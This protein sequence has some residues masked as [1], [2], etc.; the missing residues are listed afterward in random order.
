MVIWSTQSLELKEFHRDIPRYAMLSHVWGVEGEEVSFR[1]FVSL[2]TPTKSKSGFHKIQGACDVAQKDGVDWIWIDTNCI[3]KSSSAELTE[4]INS[5]YNWYKN[6]DVCYAYLDDVPWFD[7]AATGPG[8]GR[9]C[10]RES[11]WLLRGWTLQ[12]LIAPPRLEFFSNEWRKIGDRKDLAADISAATGIDEWLLYGGAAEGL[13]QVSTAKKMSWAAR[14]V[15]TRIEDVAYCLLGIFDVNMPLLYGE[16]PKA[17]MRLQEEIIKTTNDHTIFCWSRNESVPLKWTSMLAP[18]PAAFL[19]AGHYVP[20]DAWDIPMPC[21]MTNLGLSI[22]LPVIYTLTQLFVVLDAVDGTLDEN[23]MRACIAVQRTNPRRSGSNILDRN[24]FINHPVI[25]SK[26]A[27]DTRE[28]YHLYIWSRHVRRPGTLHLHGRYK[29]LGFK[30]GVLLFVDPTATR[31]LSPGR[32]DAPLGSMGY[33]II[34][35]PPGSFDEDTALFR[36][37]KGTEIMSSALMRIRFK[38]PQEPDIYLFFAVMTTL[39]GKEVWYCSVHLAEEVSYIKLALRETIAEG[40]LDTEEGE[41]LTEEALIYMSIQSDAWKKNR[42]QLTARTADESL[43]VSV[44]GSM[45]LQPKANVRAAMLSGKCESQYS[46]PVSATD[47]SPVIYGEDEEEDYDDGNDDDDE[48]MDDSE[49]AEDW[50][51]S[52]EGK[53]KQDEDRKSEEGFPRWDANSRQSSQIFSSQTLS[54]AS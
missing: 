16:G 6:A 5:M 31:L 17:F 12:E 27:T 36:L 7:L 50:S 8:E 15:T 14:R 9:H 45:T 25:L 39:T 41:V 54:S 53:E 42:R 48:Y 52:N 18:S 28:R 37:R 11:H 24:R 35:Y 38:S 30:Y 46:V 23:H 51:S 2:S 32:R 10:F 20:A 3:D 4:A 49:G 22:H 33:D 29:P 1:D 40:G 47:L 19:G 26:E 43:F 13:H 34:T 21:S 44:G